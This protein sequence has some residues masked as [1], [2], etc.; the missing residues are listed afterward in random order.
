M[1]RF[2]LLEDRVAAVE[3]LAVPVVAAERVAWVALRAAVV[4]ERATPVPEVVERAT[5]LAEERAA[6]VLTALLFALER[7]AAAGRVAAAREVDPAELRVATLP[8]EVRFAAELDRLARPPRASVRRGWV[9]LLV[10]K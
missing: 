10:L 8:E 7:V 4:E 9:V 6:E 1:E 5:L 2:T 3:R